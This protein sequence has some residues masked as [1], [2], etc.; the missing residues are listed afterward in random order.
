MQHIS[1]AV[2]WVWWFHVVAHSSQPCSSDSSKMRK[3]LDNE[4]LL[5]LFSLSTLL[6]RD[7]ELLHCFNPKQLTSSLHWTHEITSVCG[8]LG[9][10]PKTTE[11]TICAVGH[12]HMP[13]HT[14][15]HNSSWRREECKC[16]HS[17]YSLK[18]RIKTTDV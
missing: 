12:A 18:S 15:T 14:Q 17:L 7:T 5:I 4:K 3:S 1:V 11:N 13:T 6:C 8:V 10:T 9:L 2:A 16:F